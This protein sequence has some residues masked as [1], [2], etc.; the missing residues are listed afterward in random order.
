MDNQPMKTIPT[1]NGGGQ[2]RH[3][4]LI[5]DDAE[6]ITFS[7]N[8][9][10]FINLVNPWPYLAVVDNNVAIRE[11]QIAEHKAEYN[12]YL[13]CKAVKDFLRK[14]IVKSVDEEW[15]TELVSETMGYQQRYPRELIQH[16]HDTGTDLD[17]MDAKQ[18]ADNEAIQQAIRQAMQSNQ[19]FCTIGSRP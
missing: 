8:G 5:I 15:I 13:T 9:E 2:N 18:Q 7:H 16:L 14:A 6:Y 17:H 10:H 11:L 19:P 4:G 3:V 12:E 1:T